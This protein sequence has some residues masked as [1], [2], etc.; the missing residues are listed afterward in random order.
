M[1]SGS[2]PHQPLG[3][4]VGVGVGAGVKVAAT[5]ELGALKELWKA[6]VYVDK[7]R[8]RLSSLIRLRLRLIG[9]TVRFWCRFLHGLGTHLSRLRLRLIGLTSAHTCPGLG[10]GL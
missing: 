8:L 3:Y 9:L 6:D 2:N 5:V 10:L 4:R 7:P 1:R